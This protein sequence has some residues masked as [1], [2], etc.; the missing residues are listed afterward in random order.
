MNCGKIIRIANDVRFYEELCD[1]LDKSGHTTK[2]KIE[3]IKAGKGA[4]R[5]EYTGRA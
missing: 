2:G 4:I 3:L 5:K 1:G